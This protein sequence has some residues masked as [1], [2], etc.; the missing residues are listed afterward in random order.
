MFEN[1]RREMKALTTCIIKRV[2]TDAVTLGNLSTADYQIW[3]VEVVWRRV[4]VDLDVKSTRLEDLIL[5]SKFVLSDEAN[6]GL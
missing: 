4:E 6:I 5:W 1:S 3:R 2:S